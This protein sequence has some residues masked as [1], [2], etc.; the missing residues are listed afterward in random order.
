MGLQN[1]LADLTKSP[2]PKL[3]FLKRAES[4]I[5]QGGQRLGVFSGSFNPPTI[6]HVRLCE[7]AQEHLHLHEV[8]LLLTIVNV[9]KEQFD[10]SLEERVKM[11]LAVAQERPNWSAALCS[12]GRFV[13]KAQAVSNAYPEGTEIWFIVGLDTL[14]RIFESRFYQDMP[15]HEALKQFFR[16]ALLA[17]FPRGDADE[18]V[19][20]EFVERPEVSP[21]A[22]RIAILPSEPSITWVS[23]TLVRKKLMLGEEVSELVPKP[24]IKFLRP[25]AETSNEKPET[26]V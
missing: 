15:M 16:L 1:I 23:S 12:H 7:H 9:D 17:A 25:L 22:D 10:F 21:Y 5:S 3:G 8:L 24:V 4:G 18:K 26:R 11:M 6:A 19:V 20:K 2:K 13:E 14:V